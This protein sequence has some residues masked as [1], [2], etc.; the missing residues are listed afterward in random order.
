MISKPPK[1]LGMAGRTNFLRKRWFY[2]FIIYNYMATL[3][4]LYRQKLPTIFSTEINL[5][6]ELYKEEIKDAN[7]YYPQPQQM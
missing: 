5:D 6:P 1:R 4:N 3:A 2:E 7:T